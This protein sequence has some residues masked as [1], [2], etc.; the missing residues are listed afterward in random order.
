MALALWPAS[1]RTYSRGLAFTSS[2][3]PVCRS[4]CTVAIGWTEGSVRVMAHDGTRTLVDHYD[5]EAA[6]AQSDTMRRL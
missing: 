6:I 5:T 2:E 1:S 3:I 4:Q